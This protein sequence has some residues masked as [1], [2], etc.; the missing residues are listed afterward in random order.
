M[1]TVKKAGIIEDLKNKFSNANGIFFTDYHGLDV[2]TLS[3]LRTQLK[4]VEGEYTITKNTLLNLADPQIDLTGP[5]AILITY[6]DPLASLKILSKV[7]KD[8]GKP[9][10]KGGLFENN[11]VSPDEIIELSKMP[12]KEVMIGQLL[13]LMQAPLS[14]FASV[15]GCLPRNLMSGLTAHEKNLKGGE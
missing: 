13:G 5:T 6:G 4:D 11:L 1:P 2:N 14:Q 10:F 3:T 8:K 12:S 15:L 7:I 9:T